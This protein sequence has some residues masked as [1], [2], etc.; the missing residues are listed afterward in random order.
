MTNP[1][2]SGLR[3]NAHN[4]VVQEHAEEVARESKEVPPHG[5]VKS[6]DDKS[7]KGGKG[8]GVP[9]DQQSPYPS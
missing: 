4:P 5:G 1:Q 6:R 3:R 8:G 2:A 9:P 7:R